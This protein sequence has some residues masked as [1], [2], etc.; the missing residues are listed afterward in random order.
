MSTT[1]DEWERHYDEGH[2]W[3]YRFNTRTGESQWEGA[4]SSAADQNNSSSQACSASAGGSVELGAVSKRR[5]VKKKRKGKKGN[6]AEKVTTTTAMSSHGTSNNSTSTSTNNPFREEDGFPHSATTGGAIDDD[7]DMPL[8]TDRSRV[9]AETE[10]DITC[11]Y[12]LMFVTAC[13]FEAPL[14]VLE[15]SVRAFLFFCLVMLFIVLAILREGE[16]DYWY[17]QAKKCAR[18]TLL[19]VAIILTFLVPFSG[20][21]VYRKYVCCSVIPLF[22]LVVSLSI[23]LSRSITACLPACIL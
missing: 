12:R 3:W 14:A 6:E 5:N 19:C 7:D 20:C 8:I 23:S 4:E 15:G 11:Y 13:L 2:G 21:F 18:E 16:R 10:H 17:I 1:P 9:Y 22:S